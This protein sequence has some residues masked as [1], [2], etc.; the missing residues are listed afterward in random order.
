M[1][2]L[3]V[4]FRYGRDVYGGAEYHLRKLTDEL[5]RKGLDI[6]IVTTTT[7]KLTPLIKSGVLWVSGFRLPNC[8]QWPSMIRK[9]EILATVGNRTGRNSASSRPGFGGNHVAVD[10]S[11]DP[12]GVT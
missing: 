1:R 4:T 7:H 11:G 6:D 12:A 3:H 10:G 9:S 5:I 8:Q 2:V